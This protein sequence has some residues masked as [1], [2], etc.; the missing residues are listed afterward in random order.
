M[1][2]FWLV[3]EYLTGIESNRST[4]TDFKISPLSPTS[5][6]G[7]LMKGDLKNYGANSNYSLDYRSILR[8][9]NNPEFFVVQII[10]RYADEFN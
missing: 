6:R 7:E 3:L 1:S 2:P 8:F 9:F 5:G 4:P 10:A